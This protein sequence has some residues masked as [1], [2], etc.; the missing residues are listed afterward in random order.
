LIDF[1]SARK[2]V[3]DKTVFHTVK[4]LFAGNFDVRAFWRHIGRPGL[5]IMSYDTVV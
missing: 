5:L 1:R 4:L 2:C 3:P